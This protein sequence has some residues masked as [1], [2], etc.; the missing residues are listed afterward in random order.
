MALS[1]K[2]KLEKLTR[3]LEQVQQQIGSKNIAE[4]KILAESN[5]I[6][7]AVAMLVG[8]VVSAAHDLDIPIPTIDR[9]EAREAELAL[10]SIQMCL[11]LVDKVATVK[12]DPSLG[13]E[14]HEAL[15]MLIDQI[16]TLNNDPATRAIGL[17]TDQM[18]TYKK[19]FQP[20]VPT[21]DAPVEGLTRSNR[22]ASIPRVMSPPA[23]NL[24]VH[25][26]SPSQRFPISRTNHL[27]SA[28]SSSNLSS[29]I[30]QKE[31]RDRNGSF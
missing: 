18:A 8:K 7:T 17:S 24:S 6:L 26:P 12:S 27:R 11:K 13:A 16:S 1:Y 21:A 10:K 3:T 15:D 29:S 25:H 22:K 20:F 31:E 9:S 28:S 19:I 23:D 30:T 2:S 5:A 4:I 14:N